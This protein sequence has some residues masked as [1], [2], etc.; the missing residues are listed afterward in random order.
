MPR[1]DLTLLA[2][3]AVVFGV[4]RLVPTYDDKWYKTIVKPRYVP[5]PCGPHLAEAVAGM[6]FQTEMSAFTV[7]CSACQTIVLIYLQVESSKL[8]FPSSVDP[9]E[10][11]AV[12]ESYHQRLHDDMLC[13]VHNTL[14]SFP[15]HAACCGNHHTPG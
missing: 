14:W 2:S 1:A 6:A 9:T 13:V 8:G 11:A 4:Q 5:M 7:S 10:G 12:G 15:M 3:G